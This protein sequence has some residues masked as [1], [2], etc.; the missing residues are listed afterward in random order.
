MIIFG[1]D[2]DGGLGLSPAESAECYEMRRS[3]QKEEEQRG[4]G[5]E[6]NTRANNL[7]Q[8]IL[9]LKYIYIY[10]ITI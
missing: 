10:I 9:L 5:Y 1:R 7:E 8:K 2:D 4:G 3:L 6:K